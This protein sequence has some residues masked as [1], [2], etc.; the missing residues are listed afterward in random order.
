MS[1]LGNLLGFIPTVTQPERV[2]LESAADQPVITSLDFAYFVRANGE[3]RKG[4]YIAIEDE[5]SAFTS[6]RISVT[7]YGEDHHVFENI[8]V[9]EDALTTFDD[10]FFV[11]EGRSLRVRFVGTTSADLLAAYIQGFDVIQPEG[12]KHA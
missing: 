6:V 2:L 11:P 3:S 12:A 8:T 10:D 4:H 9:A 7:G 5:D 1:E